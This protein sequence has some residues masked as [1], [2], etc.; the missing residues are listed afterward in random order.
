M[1]DTW[2][3]G[4]NIGGE[5]MGNFKAV[6]G[7]KH[8]ISCLGP[9]MCNIVGGLTFGFGTIEGC[10]VQE[11]TGR[12][13]YPRDGAGQGKKSAGWGGASGVGQYLSDVIA[14]IN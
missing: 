2:V 4:E 7:L 9:P 1:K 14:D 6:E 5:I 8:L 10:S 3:F 12:P 11:W 13:F